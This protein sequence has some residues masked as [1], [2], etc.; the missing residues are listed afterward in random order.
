MIQQNNNLRRFWFETKQGFGLGITAYSLE[1]AE[2][3]I[4]RANLDN[5]EVLEVIEDIDIQTLDQ[6]HII[7]NMGECNFRGVWF[8][9]I[10]ILD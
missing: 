3:L 7:P 5:Y 9:N 6:N 4:K 1:D 10:R 8:P 2:L